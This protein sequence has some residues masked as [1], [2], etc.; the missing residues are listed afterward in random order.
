MVRKGSRVQVPLL[1]P[2]FNL[3]LTMAN[4]GGKSKKRIL[5]KLVSESG[6]TY[7]TYKNPRKTEKKL[8]LKKYDPNVRKHVIFV[9]KK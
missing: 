2:L 7:Y 9:E 1:A 6:Y 5:I 3:F 8:E 4:K